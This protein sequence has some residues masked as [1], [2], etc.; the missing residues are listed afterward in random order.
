M[1]GE[2][3]GAIVGGILAIA[4]APYIIAGAAAIGVAY[5]AIKIGGFLIGEAADYAAEK[6]REKELVVDRCSTEL[7][8]LFADMRSVVREETASHTEF[9]KKISL[10]FE[11]HGKSLKESCEGKTDVA[12]I[13]KEISISK[14]AIKI[15]LSEEAASFRKEIMEAGEARMKACVAKIDAS[16]AEKEALIDWADKSEAKVALQESMAISMLRDA[17]ATFKVIESMAKSSKDAAFAAQVKSIEASLRTAR[18]MMDAH[19]YQGV[20]SNAKTVIR[21]GAML[22]SEQ[23]QSELEMDMIAMALKAKIMG[24]IDEL[25]AQRYMEFVDESTERKKKVKVD[26]NS[27]SQGKYEQMLKDLQEMADSVT[28]LTTEA[29][30]EKTEAKFTDE[31]EPEAHRIVD[32]SIQV[33]QAYYDKIHAL[34]VV[35]DFMTQQ[36]YKMDWVMPVGGDRSQKIVVHFVQNKTGNTISI[37]LD[38]DISAGDLAKMSMEILTFYGDGRTVT[39]EEKKR[40]REHLNKALADAGYSGQLACTGKVG[41]ASERVELND[42]ESV[43]KMDVTPVV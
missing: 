8:S 29:E 28:G 40:L 7:D 19:M 24:L 26:L 20:V 11:K 15:G 31:V 12:F 43:Q 34:E 23:V 35:A 16:N 33:M 2:S 36:D 13:E 22:A 5:G 9:A 38:K 3:G 25:N 39:E 32:C 41:Q 42:R 4:V 30:V 6:K 1:S 37:T 27:Y 18:S 17:E 10:E 14:E 21:N